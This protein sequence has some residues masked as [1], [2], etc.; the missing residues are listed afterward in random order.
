MIIFVLA[1]EYDRLVRGDIGGY[2]KILELGENLER[3]GHRAIV[4]TPRLED[5][6]T[7]TP[8][9]V[10]D[11]PYVEIPLL[12]PLTVYLALFFYPLLHARRMRPDILYIRTLHS[13]LPALLARLLSAPLIVE[14]NGDSY[15]QQEAAGASRLKLALI[16]W[17]DR[18][19]L[20]SA[21][22]VI[23]ITRGLQRMVHTRY[24]IPL[25]KTAV[26]GSG[27]NVELF[28]PEDPQR[29]RQELGLDPAGPYVGF[30]GSFFRYQGIDT[31]IEAAPAI[32]E[33]V[34]D[35]RFLI[36]G[37]GVMREPWLEKVKERG[38]H[39]A[40]RFPGR[41]PY[42]DAAHYI[43]AMDVCVAP[44]V[45]ARGETSPLKLFD[46][47]ACG[48][49]VVVGDIPP[50][51][52]LIGESR[53]IVGVPPEDPKALAEAIVEL[54]ADPERQRRLG[55]RGR[56]F[57]VADHSWGSIARKVASLCRQAIEA[58]TKRSHGGLEGHG[59]KP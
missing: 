22:R 58:R 38:L 54:L 43:N 1:Y 30:V 37:D 47:L 12:R 42:V 21:D 14:V 13:P 27:S 9:K 52:E 24:G 46:Y 40:F 25:E 31:L 20:T 32:L 28:K 44:F 41:V 26:V 23:P 35:A 39:S 45:S 56:A 55:E 19:N 4:F 7:R 34:P 15:G 16:R 17:I 51:R 29:C 3:L 10:V 6:H 18:I 49:P 57:V 2:R 33:R 11:V 59:K 8:I 48:K 50:V 5:P 53:G 36:V